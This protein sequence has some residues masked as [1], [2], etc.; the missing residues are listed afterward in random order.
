[1]APSNKN[2]KA[3]LAD[4]ASKAGVSITTAS[5]VL[6]H[7]KRVS[8]KVA[9][10]VESAAADLGYFPHGLA[11]SLRTHKTFTVGLVVPDITNP[12]FA[13]V[14]YSIE[15]CL[16]ENGYMCMLCNTGRLVERERQY[17]QSLVEKSIDGL[18]LISY[19]LDS[20]HIDR[21]SRLTRLPTVLVDRLTSATLD[22]VRTDNRM[23]AIHGVTYLA[24]KGHRRISTIA[25]PPTLLPA[26]ERLD[27]FR[28]G[29]KI[30]GIQPDES[31]IR[32]SDFSVRGGYDA[33]TEL[34]KL[35]PRPDAVMVANNTMG[36]GAF[37]AL[38][39]AGINVP[40]DISMLMFD[41]VNLADVSSPTITVIAQSP[42][43]IGK[44]AVQMLMERIK[45]P[46]A[47][48]EGRQVLVS[49]RLIMRESA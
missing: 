8:A 17:I 27:G 15:Q 46:D 44:I 12:F 25:G 16:A 45:D 7:S 28:E 43:E 21:V 48:L 41:D 34:L 33:M 23:G 37:R 5:R 29:L 14:S 4:V 26:R 3:T 2:G 22:S 30:C 49:P 47:Y 32:I 24:G 19:E 9:H 31:L 39:T 36:I 35:S 38:K 13:E 40:C 18:V 6:N 42:S 1:M 10:R 20:K 11:R